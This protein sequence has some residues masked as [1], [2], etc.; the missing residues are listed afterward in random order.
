M[1]NSH[2]P[3]LN[4][5][6]FTGAPCSGKTSTLLE[7]E[8][9]TDVAE[10]DI[11]VVYEMARTYIDQQIEKGNLCAFFVCVFCVCCV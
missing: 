10:R 6:I 9:N 2:I 11:A 1:A 5:F 7:I 8:R 4:W 3:L